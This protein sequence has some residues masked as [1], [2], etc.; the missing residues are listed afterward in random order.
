MKPTYKYIKQLVPHCPVCKNQLA[1]NNSMTF[2]YVCICGIWLYNT[3]KETF[4]I[5]ENI[6]KTGSL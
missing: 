2:P 5:K 1:G 3:E 4:I 6:K